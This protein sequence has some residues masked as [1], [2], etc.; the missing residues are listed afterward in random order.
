MGDTGRF[1]SSLKE[2]LIQLSVQNWQT[3][4]HSSN[5]YDEYK[6]FKSMI[7]SETYFKCLGVFEQ[8]YVRDVYC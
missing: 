5:R 8:K 3:N 6:S 2:K 7:M 4:L 1:I